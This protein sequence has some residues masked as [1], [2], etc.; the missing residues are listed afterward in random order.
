MLKLFFLF[1]AVSF[2]I[3][4]FAQTND[5]H[6]LPE[7]VDHLSDTTLVDIYIRFHDWFESHRLDNSYP[8]KYQ[9]L[10]FADQIN[11]LDRSEGVRTDL[12]WNRNK[13]RDLTGDRL[14][15]AYPLDSCLSYFSKIETIAKEKIKGNSGR[16]RS[17]AQLLLARSLLYRGSLN[18]LKGDLFRATQ[19]ILESVRLAKESSDSALYADGY[20]KLGDVYTNEGRLN[21]ALEAYQQAMEIYR[22][23]GRHFDVATCEMSIAV[24]Q[25]RMNFWGQ[26][27]D[28]YLAAVSEFQLQG[29]DE[30]LAICYTSIAYAY[31]NQEKLN[32]S[33]EYDKKSLALSEKLSDRQGQARTY[34]SIGI[35]YLQLREF[36]ESEEYHRKA[37][38]IEKELNNRGG[39]ANSYGDLAVLYLNKAKEEQSPEQRKECIELAIEHCHRGLQVA[40][41]DIE[42]L[43]KLE[44]FKVLNLTYKLKGDYRHAIDWSDAYFALRDTLY[45]KYE[46]EAIAEL[47]VRYKTE[48]QEQQIELQEQELAEQGKLLRKD[49]LIIVVSLITLLLVIFILAF[50]YHHYRQ[51]SRKNRILHEKNALIRKQQLEIVQQIEKEKTFS[52]QVKELSDFK[53]RMMGMIVHDLKN[54]LNGILSYEY[55]D[56]EE[57][58]KELVVHSANEMLLLVQNILDVYK[59]NTTTVTIHPGRV[60][61]REVIES[62]KVDLMF[63]LNEKKLEIVLETPDFPFINA[64]PDL[65]KRIIANLLGNAVKFSP[66]NGRISIRATLIRD[67]DVRIG[68]RNQG[69]VIPKEKQQLI[70]DP[71][72]QHELRNIGVSASTGLGLTFCKM[73]VEAHHGTIGVLSEP[74]QETEFWFI[75]PGS[76]L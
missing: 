62:E 31:R 61:I 60:D 8:Y 53:E 5:D 56:D 3:G 28:V 68:I 35:T 19:D 22:T 42:P 48:R 51:N 30:G 37:L 13:V 69:A 50:L 70:F 33:L 72:G 25:A 23:L 38:E 52:A 73:A 44:L 45:A 64:D 76:V 71:F 54:P 57:S 39:I 40:G 2:G 24:G 67:T 58:R 34:N 74:G 12:I 11:G 17:E 46:S 55:I 21:K 65:L 9:E 59:S 36:N 18:Y 20:K 10:V 4:S 63:I 75:L 14:F 49:R 7:G 41:P 6:S 29:N 43:Q 27:V 1:L 16:L 47:E 32:E 15:E 66:V 26:S